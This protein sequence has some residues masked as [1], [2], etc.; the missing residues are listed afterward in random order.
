MSKKPPSLSVKRGEKLSTAR[1]AGLTAK[2]RAIYNQ[3]TGSNLQAPQTTGG[4]RQRSFCARMT[5]AKG[6]LL[7]DEGRPT[8]KAAALKRWKC[9]E[10]EQKMLKKNNPVPPSSRAGTT[11]PTRNQIERA[12]DLYKRFS[13]HD[14]EEIG[15]VNVPAMPTVGVAIGEV[16]GILYSTIRDG[17]LEKY[18]HKFH[19]ADRPILVVSPNGKVL[20][21]LGGN[22]NF[23]ERGIVDRSDK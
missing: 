23:T 11:N 5:G 18:I 14:A 22:Y 16:D 19:K 7:D 17:V 6:A 20:Y 9:D 1:G 13:G 15:T 10:L 2:G 12:K 4:A 3:A 21:L 8:R